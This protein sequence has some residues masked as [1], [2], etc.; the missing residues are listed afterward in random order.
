M[1]TK[2]ASGKAEG[3]ARITASEVLTGPVAGALIGYGV[4]TILIA[5]IGALFADHKL[6]IPEERWK[7]LGLGASVLA[8]LLLFVG[9]LYGGF[10][11][12]RVGGIGQKGIPMALGAFVAGV[13]LA[14]LAGL[15]VKVGTS[16]DQRDTAARSLRAIGAPGDADD[17]R[18]IGTIAGVASI[19]GM[20]LGSVAGGA[21]AE[22]R[23]RVT[24]NKK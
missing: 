10:I 17:W 23:I 18:D 6:T 7:D 19:A 2:T 14:G 11:A 9:Y 5:V 13:V 3:A 8:G 4:F 15:T 24:S 20:L 12:G 22:Q 1:T 21:L 16:G